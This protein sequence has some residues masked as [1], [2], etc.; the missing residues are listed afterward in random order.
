MVKRNIEMSNEKTVVRGS[1]SDITTIN[2]LTIQASNGGGTPDNPLKIYANSRNQASLEIQVQGTDSSGNPVIMS[3]DEWTPHTSLI[4][5][6]NKEKLSWEG[7]RGWCDTFDKG[8]YIISG[9]DP[10][11]AGPQVR[12]ADDG[13]CTMTYY[14]HTDQAGTRRIAA[15]IE[16]PNVNADTADG[17]GMESSVEV[18][19]IEPLH[20][21]P[22]GDTPEETVTLQ[23]ETLSGSHN[24]LVTYING[25]GTYEKEYFDQWYDNY[26]LT[27][28]HGIADYSFGHEPGDG[29]ME[30]ITENDNQHVMLVHPRG[31]TDTYSYNF[32]AAPPDSET[33]STIYGVIYSLEMKVTFNPRDNTPCLSHIDWETSQKWLMSDGYGLNEEWA[34]SDGWYIEFHDIYGNYGT[35]GYATDTNKRG[36][37]I[38]SRSS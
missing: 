20:Y 4:F 27:I 2:T 30:Y 12:V 38:I 10:E 8:P 36:L 19:A 6:D 5:A 18:K 13:T 22:E 14:V 34:Y 23:S 33:E 37:Y 29:V 35:V 15:N 24:G 16:L 17:S 11:A 32:D 25:W 7:T 1:A 3:A 28:P 9:A 26:Y 21:S 31:R